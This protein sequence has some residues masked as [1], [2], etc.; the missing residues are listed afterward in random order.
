MA[1]FTSMLVV[2][3]VKN[4]ARYSIGFLRVVSLMTFFIDAIFCGYFH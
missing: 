1:I 3:G 4:N 2:C